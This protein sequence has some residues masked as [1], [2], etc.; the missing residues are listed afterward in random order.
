MENGFNG[1][2]TLDVAARTLEDLPLPFQKLYDE[3][4]V[5][6]KP[7]NLARIEKYLKRINKSTREIKKTVELFKKLNKKV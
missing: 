1:Y 6:I 4:E 3:G 5:R 7:E 2:G